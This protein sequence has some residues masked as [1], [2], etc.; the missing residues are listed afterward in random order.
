METFDAIY[1][2]RSIKH[3]DPEH[4]LTEEE[5]TKLLEA[6]IQSPTSFNIQ[7]W[8]FV[9]LQEP[10]LRKQVRAASFDQAQVTDASAVILLCG[11]LE[12]H[13]KDPARYWVNAPEPVQQQLVPMIGGFYSGNDQ[14]IRD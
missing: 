1:Q 10:E 4:R 6:A 3:Y 9:V 5:L 12:A 7:N 14:L 13:A 11:D 2:R 8:R